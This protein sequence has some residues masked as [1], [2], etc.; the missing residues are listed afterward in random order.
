MLA[1]NTTKDERYA[2]AMVRDML[3]FVENVPLSKSEGYHPQ[4]PSN[5]NPW[6]W[7]LL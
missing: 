7:V 6:N 4:V 3:D 1:Y 2:Q 5:R